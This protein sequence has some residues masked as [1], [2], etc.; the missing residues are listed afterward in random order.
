MVY[1]DHILQTYACQRCLTS[2]MLYNLLLVHEA[3]LRIISAGQ[4]RLVKMFI[5][6]QWHDIV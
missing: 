4:S 1:F 5:T 3:L 6:I 2:G